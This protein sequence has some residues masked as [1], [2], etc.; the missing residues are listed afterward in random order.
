MLLYSKPQKV[1]TS[2]KKNTG[3]TTVAPARILAMEMEIIL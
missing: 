3:G 2:I 1:E